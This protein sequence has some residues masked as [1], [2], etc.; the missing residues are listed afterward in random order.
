MNKIKLTEKKREE[1][2]QLQKNT[3]NN[4]VFNLNNS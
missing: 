2:K 4:R 3:K 1:L